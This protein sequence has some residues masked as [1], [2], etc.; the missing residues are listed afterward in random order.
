[1]TPREGATGPSVLR[2]A[3]GCAL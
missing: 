1:M 3:R 2:H